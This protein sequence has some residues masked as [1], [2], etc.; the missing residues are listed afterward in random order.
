MKPTGEHHVVLL[1]KP[2]G[3]L[4]LHHEGVVCIFRNHL[5]R[6]DPG[7]ARLAHIWRNDELLGDQRFNDAGV[8]P[9]GA[10]WIGGMD[11][12]LKNAMAGLFRFEVGQP[13][14]KDHG[15][16]LGNGL[17]WSPDTRWL[18]FVDTARH[19]VWRYGWSAEHGV[20][21]TRTLFAQIPDG[22]HPDGC[23]M[24]EAGCLWIA[25]ADGARIDCISPDGRVVKSIPLPVSKPTSCAFGG[26]DRKTLFITTM[27]YG[28]DDDALLAE[29]EAGKVFVLKVDTAGLPVP[30]LDSR[31]LTAVSQVQS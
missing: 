16:L 5:R 15:F 25:I 20:I 3:A 14:T 26:A 10:L 7:S 29:P 8:D 27:R 11:R 6:Y 19:C 13:I 22:G 2:I 12:H 30:L 9:V 31:C 21:G 1:D 4:A 23:A 17:A 28:L 18:Y 24:D